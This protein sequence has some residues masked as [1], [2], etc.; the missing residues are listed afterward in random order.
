MSEIVARQAKRRE[1]RDKASAKKVSQ[2]M[3]PSDVE[4]FQA[5]QQQLANATPRKDLAVPLSNSDLTS[6]NA[7]QKASAANSSGGGGFFS[8]AVFALAG[9]GGGATSQ[10]GSQSFPMDLSELITSS[11]APQKTTWKLNAEVKHSIRVH[12]S[13]ILAVDP[14]PEMVRV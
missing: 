6:P 10:A 8:S 7:D 9:A 11:S 13:A 12:S 14:H 3:K 5:Q 4:A 1:L 2:T